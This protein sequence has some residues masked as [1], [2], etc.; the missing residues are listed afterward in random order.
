MWSF[1]TLKDKRYW[2]LVIPAITIYILLAIFVPSSILENTPLLLI[3]ILIYV[4]LFWLTYHS[5][6]Y[7]GDKKKAGYKD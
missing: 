4:S 2:I 1:K 7:F 5:W 3:S 6:K